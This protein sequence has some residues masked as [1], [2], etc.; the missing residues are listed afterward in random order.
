ML[1]SD[2]WPVNA[3]QVCFTMIIGL[4]G[5]VIL[6]YIFGSVTL[7]ISQMNAQNSFYLS[8]LEQLR[9]KLAINKVPA[10]L[11]VKVM[12]Y[13]YYS[14]RKHKVL[15]KSTNFEEL[16]LPLQRD[17]A[18]YQ[19]KETIMKVPLFLELE[20]IEILSIIRRLR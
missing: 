12:E 17:L 10:N 16:S 18:F 20:P 11:R 19:Y 4:T 14:W 1:G 7:L 13:F 5:A 15:Q 3:V 6:G 9:N 8:K 2:L